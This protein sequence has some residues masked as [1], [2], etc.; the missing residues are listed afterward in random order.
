V[1]AFVFSAPQVLQNITN[2]PRAQGA[3]RAPTV[4]GTGSN[5]IPLGPISGNK[6]Q[7]D[8]AIY[9]LLFPPKRQKGENAGQPSSTSEFIIHDENIEKG[10]PTRHPLPHQTSTMTTKAARSKPSKSQR[11]ARQRSAQDQM[12]R[13]SFAIIARIASKLRASAYALAVDRDTLRRRWD[14]D[15]NLQLQTVTDHFVDLSE[16][17][18]VAEDGI[19]DALDVVER[20]L[21]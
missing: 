9:T 5:R 7:R 17:F 12:S 1:P 4:K 10:P 11:K 20:R 2:Q 8:D 13:D 16:Y 19:R 6:R 18:C 3:A 21:L 14:V 15:E